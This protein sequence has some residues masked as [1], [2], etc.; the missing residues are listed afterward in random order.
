M[1]AYVHLYRLVDGYLFE[2]YVDFIDYY[3]EVTPDEREQILLQ[4]EQ[5]KGGFM[6][7]EYLMGEG[8]K[9]GLKEGEKIGVKKGEKI[10]VKKGKVEITLKQLNLK[11]RDAAQPY[12]SRVRESSVEELDRIA[13]R[14]LYAKTIEAVFP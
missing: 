7:R 12:E 8:K 10:G 5:H 14:L 2:K 13:E 6:I 3:G 1:Q 9:I 4:L 11:F